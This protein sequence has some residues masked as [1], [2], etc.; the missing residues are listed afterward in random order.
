MPVIGREG[1]LRLVE[2]AG[3]LPACGLGGRRAVGDGAGAG[4][5]SR[6]WR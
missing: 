4:M 2:W 6:W 5:F 1:L 3:Q